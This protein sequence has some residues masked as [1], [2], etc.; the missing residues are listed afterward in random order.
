MS[1]IEVVR[2]HPPMPL[3]PIDTS[4]RIPDSVKRAGQMADAI[5]AQA[6]QTQPVIEP[7][8]PD[9]AAPESPVAPAVSTAP[10][11]VIEPVTPEPPAP[12]PGEPVSAEQWE[13]RYNSM[14][15]RYDALARS[16]GVL[17]EQMAQMGDELMRT[18]ALLNQVPPTQLQPQHQNGPKL[19]TAA[20]EEQFGKDIIDLAT[21]VAQ[22][23]V[24]PELDAVKQENANLRRTMQQSTQRTVYQQ[25]DTAVPDWRAINKSPRFVS[26]LRLPDIY[27]RTVRHELLNRAFDA[28]DAASV[29]AFFKG[30]IT[31]EAATGNREVPVPQ[32]AA[33][34]SAPVQPQRQ[35]AIQ[36]ETLT[37][38]GRAKPA[39][40][41]GS[42]VPVD[43]PYF[44][45][46]QVTKFYDQVRKGAYV[47]REQ[48]KEIDEQA[49][50]AAQRDGRI[51]G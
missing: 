23:T 14:K 45:R 37:A 28:A 26:W 34:A 51:K 17:Q 5:H 41:E 10:E 25:L 8:A 35:A 29:I 44:T 43:K 32:P 27:S 2:D 46:F 1:A 11:P 48:Q 12:V 47:G 49:I 19:V 38:P 16:N 40:G 33:A 21:R 6:Y 31:D 20:D 39:T 9:P 42:T 50:F 7:V 24:A 15:G 22:Q 3:A 13:H 18:Q 30:F 36:L 4:V